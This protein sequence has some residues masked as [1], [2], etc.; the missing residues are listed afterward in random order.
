MWQ[1][2]IFD[3]VRTPSGCGKPGEGGCLKP[4][5]PVQILRPWVQLERCRGRKPDIRQKAGV[6][7]GGNVI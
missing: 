5:R 1:A 2:I 3:A 6:T 7:M 4:L